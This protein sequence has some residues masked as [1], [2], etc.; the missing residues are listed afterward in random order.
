M[1]SIVPQFPA[2]PLSR[3]GRQHV[4]LAYVHDLVA[5]SVW[6]EPFGGIVIEAFAQGVPVIGSRIG[7][8]A[9]LCRRP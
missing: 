6:N 9:E 5:P 2:G 3:L 1:Q 8:I 4:V 7:G